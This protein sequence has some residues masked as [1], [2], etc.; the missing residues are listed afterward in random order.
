MSRGENISPIQCQD[1]PR[2]S[3]K[4]GCKQLAYRVHKE[5][6]LISTNFS[7]S[8]NDNELHFQFVYVFTNIVFYPL[9]TW[10]LDDKTVEVVV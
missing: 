7:Q 4:I 1:L 2:D 3:F 10:D 6:T 9:R 5:Q 8:L